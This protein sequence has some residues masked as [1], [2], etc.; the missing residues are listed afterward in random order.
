M[1]WSQGNQ[2]A[3]RDLQVWPPETA[4]GGEGSPRELVYASS[5]RVLIW[6]E[7]AAGTRG[8]ENWTGSKTHLPPPPCHFCHMPST[9]RERLER[10][11]GTGEEKG[12]PTGGVES[13]TTH[14]SCD[15]AGFLLCVSLHSQH[16]RKR[17]NGFVS[18]THY[19]YY[20]I[21]CVCL[22]NISIRVKR[23]PKYFSPLL[24][25][26]RGFI[27]LLCILPQYMNIWRNNY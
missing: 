19:L 27:L 25:I 20:K 12:V 13:I 3:S 7:C 4:R 17:A 9:R 2:T 14:V 16:S 22:K 21:I 15:T 26:P 1:A 8:T 11:T 10:E 23:T 18:S 6:A 5:S 24:S